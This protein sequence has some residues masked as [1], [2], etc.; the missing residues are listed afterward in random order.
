MGAVFVFSVLSVQDSCTCIFLTSEADCL[1]YCSDQCCV[2]FG[3]VEMNYSILITAAV[4]LQRR[5]S[6]QVGW[7]VRLL[8]DPDSNILTTIG[9]IAKKVFTDTHCPQKMNLTDTGDS[10]TCH[11][12]SPTGQSYCWNWINLPLTDY[13]IHHLRVT[14]TPF[15]CRKLKKHP[16]SQFLQPGH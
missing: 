5:Q 11:R 15:L 10:M 8:V 2:L 6:H 9:G 14:V 7:E 12:L 16:Q 13:L 1:A 4:W 3:L